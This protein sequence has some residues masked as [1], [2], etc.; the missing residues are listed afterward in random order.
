ME[1]GSVFINRESLSTKML[2]LLNCNHLIFNSCYNSPNQSL[3]RGFCK[4]DFAKQF[5]VHQ[6][7]FSTKSN[8]INISAW[9]E[10]PATKGEMSREMNPILLSQGT[11]VG[12]GATSC[13]PKEE[14][15]PPG[16]GVWAS[17]LPAGKAQLRAKVPFF[18]DFPLEYFL[19]EMIAIGG[20]LS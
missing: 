11:G 14:L 5:A 3:R 6:N 7:I 1:I 19:P 4:F 15:P 8:H 20:A 17:L 13:Q 12:T 9:N 18:C 10:Q 2:T 16:G